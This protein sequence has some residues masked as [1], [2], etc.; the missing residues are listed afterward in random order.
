LASW[1]FNFLLFSGVVSWWS[2]HRQG[3]VEFPGFR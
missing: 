1:R 2:F 3:G